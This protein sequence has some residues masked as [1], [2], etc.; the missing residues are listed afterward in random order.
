MSILNEIKE[1]STNFT[2]QCKSSKA[3]LEMML[4]SIKSE[5]LTEDVYLNSLNFALSVSET[6]K[7]VIEMIKKEM[8]LCRESIDQVDK[9][10]YTAALGMLLAIDED[11]NELIVLTKQ[12]IEDIRCKTST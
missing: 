10:L 7:P 11:I 9:R 4:A 2:E 6:Y 8:Y 3:T 1:D 12:N 5:E